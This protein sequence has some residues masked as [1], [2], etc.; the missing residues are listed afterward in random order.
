M[1]KDS[2]CITGAAALCSLSGEEI[3]RSCQIRGE[4]IG[5]KPLNR[6]KSEKSVQSLNSP[7]DTFC[8][9]KSV[10]LGQGSGAGEWKWGA[11]AVSWGDNPKYR[12]QV[13][14]KGR[15][16]RTAGE[17]TT[18]TPVCKGPNKVYR[19]HSS[20]FVLIH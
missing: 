18:V 1:L 3:Y 15:Q 10:K 7:V 6:V 16:C 5:Q 8:W 11:M 13:T 20:I 9:G 19:L 4:K 12:R 17:R 14:R 2:D